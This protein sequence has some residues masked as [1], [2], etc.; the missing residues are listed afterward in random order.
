MSWCWIKNFPFAHYLNLICTEF[1]IRYIVLKKN[2]TVVNDQQY[3]TFSSELIF[4]LYIRVP[5][6][7]IY[8]RWQVMFSANVLQTSLSDRLEELLH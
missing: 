3:F 2:Q 7:I 8:M 1:Y 6:T 4:C 5:Q